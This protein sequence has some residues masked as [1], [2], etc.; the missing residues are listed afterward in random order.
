MSGTDEYNESMRRGQLSSEQYRRLLLFSRD[1]FIKGH[2]E[3]GT[4][5]TSYIHTLQRLEHGHANKPMKQSIPVMSSP[6][7]D[8]FWKVYTE[9]CVGILFPR[10]EFS[11]AISKLGLYHWDA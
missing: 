7:Q 5:L 2:L 10:L 4:S 1:G 3:L 11:K 6:A 8:R 9:R